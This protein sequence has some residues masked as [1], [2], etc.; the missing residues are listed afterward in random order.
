MRGPC[1]GRSTKKQ[2]LGHECSEGPC[3]PGIFWEEKSSA[4]RSV[5][6]PSP[7]EESVRQRTWNPAD[8]VRRRGPRSAW[9]RSRR[10]AQRESATSRRCIA[11]PGGMQALLPVYCGPTVRQRKQIARSRFADTQI[12]S[13]AMYVS[14]RKPTRTGRTLRLHFLRPRFLRDGRLGQPFKRISHEVFDSSCSSTDGFGIERV[15][16]A[17]RG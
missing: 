12:G 13:C 11:A 10:R 14:E 9:S 7:L 3:T 15:R 5:V 4:R 2:A 1:H 8:R 16:K 6:S 17:D